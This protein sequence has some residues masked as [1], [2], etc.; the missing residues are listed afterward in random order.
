VDINGGIIIMTFLKTV[1]AGLLLSAMASGSAFAENGDNEITYISPSIIMIG[2][3]DPCDNGG[4]D[5]DVAVIEASGDSNAA[6]VDA[7]GMPTSMPVIMRPSVE[8]PAASPTPAAT[9]TAPAA[10]PASAATPAPVAAT[11]APVDAPA[12]TSQTAPAPGEE[13]PSAVAPKE[14]S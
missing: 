9:T 5:E 13:V 3:P 11:P 14:Q 4:C 2:A 6:L 12:A 1:A 7:Y 10:T 8:T